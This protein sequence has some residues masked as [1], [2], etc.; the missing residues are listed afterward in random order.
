M[1][2]LKK[3][4]KRPFCLDQDGKCN[5]LAIMRKKKISSFYPKQIR[6][7]VLLKLVI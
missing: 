6:R 1:T 3:E 5:Q 2:T 7:D 4:I